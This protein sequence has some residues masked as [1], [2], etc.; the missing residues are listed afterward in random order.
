MRSGDYVA[1]PERLNYAAYRASFFCFSLDW[2]SVASP[3][4][5]SVGV[6]DEFLRAVVLF[7]RGKA[8]WTFEVAGQVT[9]QIEARNFYFVAAS[10]RKA[11]SRLSRMRDGRLRYA[12]HRGLLLDFLQQTFRHFQRNSPHTRRLEE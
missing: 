9:H 4:S 11:R 8:R 2:Q 12:R 7:F 10:P 3:I 5:G 6:S 1:G